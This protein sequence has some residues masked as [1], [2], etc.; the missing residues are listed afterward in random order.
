VHSAAPALG[1]PGFQGTQY[2]ADF[3]GPLRQVDT[4]S[5][6]PT[7]PPG[8][9]VDRNIDTIHALIKDLGSEGAGAYWLNAVR[10]GGIWDYK[11]LTPDLRY[12]SFGNFNYGATGRALGL[13]EQVLRRGAGAVQWLGGPYDPSQGNPLGGPPYGDQPIDQYWIGRGIEYYDRRGP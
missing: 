7:T 5:S 12:E 2:P 4:L 10:E 8:V 6:I 1:D 13:P 9:D 11:R 3:V